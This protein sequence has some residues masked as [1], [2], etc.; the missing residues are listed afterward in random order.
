VKPS[1]VPQPN[2]R[3]GRPLTA[4]RVSTARRGRGPREKGMVVDR[5]GRDRASDG[6]LGHWVRYLGWQL[7]KSG[8][9]RWAR[10]VV[11]GPPICKGPKN[12]A[13]RRPTTVSGFL[14]PLLKN[15]LKRN[16]KVSHH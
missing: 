16:A 12:P 2:R 1:A 9:I 8:L 4:A 11:P 3:A 5:C 15:W 7:T 13:C 6:R 10:P 14:K